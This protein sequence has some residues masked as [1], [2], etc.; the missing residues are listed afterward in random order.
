M[1]SWI[2][3]IFSSHM[4]LC[5]QLGFSFLV[6]RSLLL[7]GFPT[8]LRVTHQSWYILQAKISVSVS[9]ERILDFQ[10]TR[11]GGVSLTTISTSLN[12]RSEGSSFYCAGQNS[13]IIV[14]IGHIKPILLCFRFIHLEIS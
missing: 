9:L 3:S 14:Q 7:N 6:I 11:Q 4:A 12:G 8:K 1:E 2:I 13:Q 10:A 5:W